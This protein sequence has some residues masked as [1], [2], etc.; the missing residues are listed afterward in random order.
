MKERFVPQV[1]HSRIEGEE[2]VDLAMDTEFLIKKTERAILQWTTLLEAL[3]K[4]KHD[5]VASDDAF[6]ALRNYLLMEID[7]AAIILTEQKNL[8]Q[9]IA[10]QQ[11]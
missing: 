1:N 7:A 5:D 4:E 3:E 2:A 10:E 11:N 8:A 6:H 9:S